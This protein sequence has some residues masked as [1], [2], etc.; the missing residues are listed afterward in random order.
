MVHIDPSAPARF[1]AIGYE[2]DDWVAVL[3]KSHETGET[4]QRIL[5]VSAVAASRFQAWLR[6]M[7][8]ARFSVY[9]SVNAVRPGRS[10]RK[11]AIA[12]VRH[13]ASTSIRKDRAF[14]ANWT[15]DETC[16]RLPTS[17]VPLQDDFTCSGG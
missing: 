14:Y 10:R 2:P 15:R 8:A 17:C 6:F 11:E 4:A 13:V 9:V 16:R 12:A 1:L 5:R 3:L 7:N